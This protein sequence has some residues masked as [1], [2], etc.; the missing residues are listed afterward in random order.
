MKRTLS[1]AATGILGVFWIIPALQAAEQNV[2]VGQVGPR[3]QFETNFF[4]F[5]RITAAETIS[6]VFKFKNIG[7]G[8][9]KI[10]KPE[11]SC[12]CTEARL[13]SDTLAP[14]ESGELNY[15]IKLERALN[16]QRHIM[17]PSN[18]PKT[19]MAQVTMQMDY[20]PLYELNPL[21]LRIGVP[22]RREMMPSRFTVTRIDGKPLDIN[23][24]TTSQDWIS[25]VF[26][27]SFK[28]QDNEA[29]INVVVH[30]P[31]GPPLPINATI[32]MWNT[33]QPGRPVRT[34]ILTGEVQGELVAD[35]SRFDWVLADFGTDISKYPAESLIRKISL[36]SVLG[37]EIE[38]KNPSTNIKGMSLQIVPKEPGKMFDLVLKFDEL[39]QE[40]IKGKVT[41]ETSLASLP[42]LEVPVTIS[43]APR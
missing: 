39:P 6:G 27:S 37:Q 9:L 15:T 10:G 43:V 1:F 7:D 31:A 33:N 24:L 20:T 30:R 41:V 5:G 18:D 13:T 28:P 22:A 42:K 19:P 3:I 40:F 35:P 32:L 25:A 34:M 2:S 23:R 14:G 8:I 38:L 26:D 4:D 12:D 36:R 17:V 16:A 29:K 21:T 11:A